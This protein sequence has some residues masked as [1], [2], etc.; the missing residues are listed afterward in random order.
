M[1]S[2]DTLGDLP[3]GA[4]CSLS[5]PRRRGV[6]C[7]PRARQAPVHPPAARAQP[8]EDGQGSGGAPGERAP[9]SL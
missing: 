2:L 9:H 7:A 8:P 3:L 5:S 1:T 6:G 4:P